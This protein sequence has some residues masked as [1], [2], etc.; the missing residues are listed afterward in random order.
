MGTLTD[1]Q[2][3]AAAIR[4]KE[5][6]ERAERFDGTVPDSRPT[7]T[8]Q[9]V[10]DDLG[11]VPVRIVRAGNQGGKSQTGAR[12]CAWVFEENHPRWKRPEAWGDE[13]LLMIV[14]CM[15]LKQFEDVIWRKLKPL[16]DPTGYRI[17]RSSSGI[18]KIVN[19]RNGNEI[20]VLS[21]HNTGDAQDKLQGFVAHWAW[22]DE[23]PYSAK[24]FEEIMRR[25]ASRSG[26]FLATF[27][28]KVRNDSI[29]RMVEALEEPTG[30]VYR[31]RMFDNPI[32]SDA[33]K[34]V[35]E[36]AKLAGLP[37]NVRNSILNGDWTAGDSAV[38]YYDHDTMTRAPQNYHCSWRHVL[39]VDPANNSET[40]VVLFAEDPADGKWYV[41][42]AEKLAGLFVPQRIVE[43]IEKLVQGY[44]IILRVYDPSAAWFYHTANSMGISY[45]GVYRKTERK[46]DLIKGLQTFISTRGYVA[47][48]CQN[49]VEELTS[50]SWSE[51][52][53]DKIVKSQR[54]HLMDAAQ[55]G[56]D[57]LPPYKPTSRADTWMSK[58]LADDDARIAKEQKQA[59]AVMHGGRIRRHRIFS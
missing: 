34:Q 41:V 45:E 35:E 53:E 40:G 8:Q 5:A 33:A 27:T 2:V 26:S 57:R 48:W 42:K 1:K 24:I 39:A 12:E 15:T 13:P 51:T 4:R 7:K 29:R 36:L 16:L 38:Y 31:F 21:Y 28:P 10:L 25:V 46:Q 54:F 9:Q 30:K 52:A 43:E 59:A 17:K 3:L 55:Y 19:T 23:M 58:L 20:L 56:V 47:P 14:G 37:E 50:C 22:V 11:T 6:M 18:E 44:N 32:Y 49:F